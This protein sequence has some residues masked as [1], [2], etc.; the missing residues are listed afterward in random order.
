MTSSPNVSLQMVQYLFG[1]VFGKVFGYAV[2]FLLGWVLP[3]GEFGKYALFQALF[4]IV[5]T[6]GAFGLFDVATMLHNKT[7]PDI[8]TGLY[9]FLFFRQ[10]AFSV[11]TSL[12]F[13]GMGYLFP[14]PEEL[15]DTGMVP[16]LIVLSGVGFLTCEWPQTWLVLQSQAGKSIALDFARTV[17]PAISGLFCVFLW[18]RSFLAFLTGHFIGSLPIVAG[19]VLWVFR[20]P[21]SPEVGTIASQWFSLAAPMLPHSLFLWVLM[22]CDRLFLKFYGSIEEVGIFGMAR[23]GSLIVFMILIAM[24]RALCPPFLRFAADRQ[25]PDEM[26]RMEKGFIRNFLASGFFLCL[27]VPEVIKFFVPSGF[28]Q[29]QQ[30]MF[31]LILAHTLDGFYFLCVNRIV[32]GQKS[33]YLA[34]V[35]LGAATGSIAFHLFFIPRYGVLGA[36]VGVFLAYVIKGILALWLARKACDI[37]FPFAVSAKGLFLF[38][39]GLMCFVPEFGLFSA[40]PWLRLG[41]GFLMILFS[42][43][44][45]IRDRTRIW[46]KVEGM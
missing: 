11:L 24:N 20:Q 4:G 17:S 42:F 31:I 22:L 28:S 2:V 1:Q 9:R 18:E 34:L 21:V 25:D 29:A 32:A 33:W 44:D 3:L 19:S 39:G 15:W 46:S 23:Q 13:L 7:P 41:G 8:R 12:G 45:A 27:I 16:V 36:A 26:R 37:P 40:S 38:A 30:P 35:S 43:F 6:I 10:F 14:Y 5:T